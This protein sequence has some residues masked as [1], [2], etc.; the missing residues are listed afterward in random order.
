MITDNENEVTLR[1]SW[2]KAL[3]IKKLRVSQIIDI[4]FNFYNLYSAAKHMRKTLVR[5]GLSAL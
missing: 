5:R 4:L 2:K 3:L 1:L